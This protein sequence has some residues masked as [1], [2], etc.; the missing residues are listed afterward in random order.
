MFERDISELDVEKVVNNGEII[1]TYSNDKPYVSY[2]ILGYIE[3]RAIH[4]VYAL[5]ENSQ[6][7]I[8]TVYEPSLDK[9]DNGFRLRKQ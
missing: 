1:K 4:V 5:D 9:W 6:T 8:I 7:I 2:L 3:K